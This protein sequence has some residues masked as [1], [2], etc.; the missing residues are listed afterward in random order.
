SCKCG[1]R[2]QAREKY[3][4]IRV[5]CPACESFV[6]LPGATSVE[7]EVAPGPAQVAWADR[8]AAKPGTNQGLL[9]GVLAAVVVIVLAAAA[10]YVGGFVGTKGKANEEPPAQKETDQKAGEQK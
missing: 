8:P 10:A 9:Y 1:E 4:G 3:A 6:R 7:H 2:L 5:R